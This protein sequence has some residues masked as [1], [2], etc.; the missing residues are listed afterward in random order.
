MFRI[1]GCLGLTSGITTVAHLNNVRRLNNDC[2]FV[3]KLSALKKHLKKS[4]VS[5]PLNNSYRTSK[6]S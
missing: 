2:I 3:F 1:R 5:C 6:H 4:L